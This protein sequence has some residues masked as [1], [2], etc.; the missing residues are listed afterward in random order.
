MLNPLPSLKQQFL[1]IGPLIAG[2]TYYWLDINLASNIAITAAVAVWCVSWW[3][4]E[5]VPIPV[6]SLLP[7]A[8]FPL[9]GVLTADQVAAAYGNKLV[10]LLLGGFLL[11]TAISHCGAHRRIALTMVHWF[12]SNN[13]KRLVMG[14]MVA[15]AILSMWISNTATTLMLLPVVL[16]II[17]SS[18][19]KKLALPLLLGLAYAAS[20]GGIGTPIGTPPNLIFMQVYE[21]NTGLQVSFTQWMSW[22][23]PLIFLFLPIV[24]LWLTRHLHNEGGFHLPT[25]GAW[26][27]HERRVMIVFGLTA[28]FWIT[29]REPF[30]G[31]SG[32]LNLPHANDASV[33]LLAVIALFITPNGNKEKLLNWKTAQQIPWGILLLFSGGICLAK[34]FVISGLSSQ[35]GDQL[36]A[37]TAFS[38]IGMMVAIA[39]CVTFLTEATSNTATTAMLMPVLVATA[40]N[41]ELDPLLL[42]IPAT[43]SASC[44]FMLPVATAPNT[45]VFSSGLVHSKKMA[46][47]G[48]V[49]N[50]IGTILITFV[51]WLI[52]VI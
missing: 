41:A 2:L 36:S 31:W 40:I 12:G 23:L 10:L 3:I 9:A 6:T 37:V 34:A 42:M 33:A 13:P 35:L 18:D 44:A 39:L 48:L 5:P 46:K 50:L 4:F 14:F 27:T 30:G 38:I 32:W 49:L 19:N 29:R 43:F 52:F 16:A 26:T 11:S 47:E 21:E 20:I 22:A 1:F 17:D 8:I 15:S 25:V 7:I 45:I 24:W 28:L 51:C